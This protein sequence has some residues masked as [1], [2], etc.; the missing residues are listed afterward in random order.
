MSDQASGGGF[1]VERTARREF[2]DRVKREAVNEVAPQPR[3]ASVALEPGEPG[4]LRIRG[5]RFRPGTRVLVDG[6]VSDV[7]FADVHELR[8]RLPDRVDA[9]GAVVA[10]NDVPVR[11][12]PG[13][14]APAPPVR[15]H[16]VEVS[17]PPLRTGEPGQLR[18]AF[19]A[20]EGAPA[21]AME[22][23]LGFP[24]GSRQVATYVITEAENREGR[25]QIGDVVVER[26][27]DLDVR[28]AIYDDAGGADHIERLL[29]V[30]PS[31][32][33]QLYAYAVS[34]GPSSWRGAATYDGG[35]NRYY[36]HARWVV[37]NGNGFSI[38]VGPE[39]RCRVTDAS[40]GE[41]ADFEFGIGTHT[42]PA[43]SSRTLHVHTWHG[44]S[45]DV[46]DLF[47]DHGDATFAYELQSSHGELDD[48]LV[49]VAAAQVG[50][51]ANFVGNFAW[52]ERAKI[53]DII[54]TWAN[55]VYDDVDL[56]FSPA[57][58]VLEIPGSHADWSRY[59]DIHVEETKSG[60]CVDSDE[61]DD[62]R[63]DWS[64]P[65][66]H[67]HR[68]DVFFVE[69][70]SGD[71]CASGLGG[72]SPID[73]PSGKGGDNS[74]VV[75]DVKDLNVLTSSWGEQVMGIIIAHEI[76]HYL[77]LEHTSAS[78]NFMNATVGSNSTSITYGQWKTMRDHHFVRRYTP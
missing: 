60:K 34:L 15:L 70:F 36:C 39:V 53:I 76:G 29:E 3:V 51:T 69:S 27:G 43:N 21:R 58:P 2:F 77:G 68:I 55:G 47:R 66:Q 37:S 67:D 31:N 4:V 72:F 1:D 18:V 41:L 73:G 22:V 6:G 42:I 33:Q 28:V 54:D 48:S 30:V 35:Q 44:S 38:T 7:E 16:D 78:N 24:D 63:D 10:T 74:G 12:F 71:A 56:V 46:Y 13:V 26:G 9:H 75:I 40:L 62:L 65:S 20:S 23:D 32:P 64:A 25:K 52:S 57:T 17:E 50:I 49:F 59:R 8:V 45:S 11:L 5:S 19:E 61:A 14:D